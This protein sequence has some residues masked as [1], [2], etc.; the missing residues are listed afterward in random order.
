MAWLIRT[1]SFDTLSDYRIQQ[2]YALAVFYYST[3]GLNSSHW[4]LDDNE[5]EWLTVDHG[6]CSSNSEVTSISFTTTVDL[7]GTIPREMELLTALEHLSLE[8]NLLKG[9]IPTEL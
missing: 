8:L 5:C 9:T 2:R 3:E 1:S 4:L 6:N 7:R